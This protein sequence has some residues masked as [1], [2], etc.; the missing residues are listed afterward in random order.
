MSRRLPRFSPVFVLLPIA[1]APIAVLPLTARAQTGVS[2]EAAPTAP[3]FTAPQISPTGPQ[4]ETTPVNPPA[5]VAPDAVA[6]ATVAP[7]AVAPATATA[8]VAA[9]SGEDKSGATTAA[10]QQSR[11][12]AA[13]VSYQGSTIIASGTPDNPVRFQSAAGL[14]L[15]DNVRLDTQTQ[16]LQASG[17]VQFERERL[18][19]RKALLPRGLPAASTTETVRETAF[20]NNLNYDFKTGQGTLDTAK[21]RLATISISTESLIINGKT[22]VARNVVLLPGGLSD[23]EIKIYGTPPFSLHAREVTL[24][25]VERNGQ[26]RQRVTLRGG[27]LYF[28]G[29]RILP[30]PSYSF[31]SGGGQSDGSRIIPGISFNSGDRVLVTTSFLFPLNKINPDRLSATADLG[32]SARVGL[33]GGL[34]LTS[35]LPVGRF[36]LNARKSDVISTQLTNRIELDR[37]PELTYSSPAFLQFPLGKQ[38]AGLIFDGSLGNFTERLIG[39]DQPVSDTRT[40]ARLVLTTRLQPGPGAFAR[41]FSTYSSYGKG[42]I[43]RNNGVELGYYGRLLPRLRGQVAVRFTDIKG[44]TPF[45][46]DQ[47]EIRRE[48]RAT[49]D[50]QL[51]PRYLVP[52]DL[53][54]DLQQNRFRDETFGI[55]RS[56]KTFAYGVTYQTARRDLRLEIRQGF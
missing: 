10:P 25:P 8:D 23:E 14:I 33:R 32:Y 1:A 47:V 13:S 52:I 50:Y 16:Q 40:R 51:S 19:E 6:P 45:R 2:P 22:Y 11:L 53:R 18:V 3:E 42:G 44:Q 27:G 7:D 5:A 38:R 9:A 15:A 37:K 30:V 29:T 28:K 55:L 4:I 41:L 56:Y 48:L 31:Y 54:Y 36:A 24:A 49:A 46:F 43:Y 26:Q 12:Q 21:L 20:G 34:G 17:K 35:T 39:R